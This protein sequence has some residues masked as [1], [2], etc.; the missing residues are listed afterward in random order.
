M[1]YPWHRAGH[2]TPQGYMRSLGGCAP[3]LGR[4]GQREALPAGGGLVEEPLHPGQGEQ[5]GLQGPQPEGHPGALLGLQCHCGILRLRRTV[6]FI[7]RALP[8]NF[9]L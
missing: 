8:Y 2:Q 7:I 9:W 6:I 1:I 3:V 4:R 5:A